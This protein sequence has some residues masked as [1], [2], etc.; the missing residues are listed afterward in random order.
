MNRRGHRHQRATRFAAAVAALAAFAPPVPAT[1]ADGASAIC[2]SRI[3]DYVRRPVDRFAIDFRQSE[4]ISDPVYARYRAD[5]SAAASALGYDPH[6]NTFT[7]HET[8]S[9]F[10][11]LN[12]GLILEA[13]LVLCASGAE[14]QNQCRRGDYYVY[15]G[16]LDQERLSLILDDIL[17]Q[18]APATVDSCDFG[19]G[20]WASLG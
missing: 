17:R 14:A 11:F 10:P 13:I 4:M 9:S 18:P 7:L 19:Q 6:D 16:L 8:L 20:G 15:D 1:L 12:R 2:V 3:Y 5:L